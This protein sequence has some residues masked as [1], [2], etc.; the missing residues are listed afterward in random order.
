MYD[1]TFGPLAF[2]AA[3]LKF[4]IVLTEFRGLFVTFDDF[5]CTLKTILVA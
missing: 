5:K 4:T 3:G 2:S 1:I